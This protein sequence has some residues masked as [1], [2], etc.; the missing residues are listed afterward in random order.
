[1]VFSEIVRDS[2]V[3]NTIHW[4]QRSC[5]WGI[6]TKESLTISLKTIHWLQ[7]SC[8]RGIVTKEF[9]AISLNTIHWLQRSCEWGIGEIVRDSLVAMPR[10]QLL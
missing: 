3:L 1:M 2:L 4:L 9:Q 7:R 8:E 10:S 6:I 5:E